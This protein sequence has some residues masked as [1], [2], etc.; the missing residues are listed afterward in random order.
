MDKPSVKPGEWIKVDGNDCV[1]SHVYEQG[2][3]L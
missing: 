1:V 2:S 3:S